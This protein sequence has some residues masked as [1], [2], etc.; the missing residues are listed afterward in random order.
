MVFGIVRVQE[1]AVVSTLL[2]DLTRDP[3]RVGQVSCQYG[4]NIT[5]LISFQ[6]IYDN[7]IIV[8]ALSEIFRK[9]WGAQK[10]GL[11]RSQ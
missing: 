2:K 3:R 8:A 4:N 1:G 10:D 6:I 11:Y 5:E 9:Q 7:A